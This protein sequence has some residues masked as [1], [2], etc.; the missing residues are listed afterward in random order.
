MNYTVVSLSRKMSGP[1]F[2][3]PDA[4]L[5]SATAMTADDYRAKLPRLSTEIVAYY[6][7]AIA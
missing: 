2:L 1:A 5:F 6:A 3:L 4:D 7:I